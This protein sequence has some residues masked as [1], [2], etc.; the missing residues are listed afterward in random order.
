[1]CSSTPT[2]HGGYELSM[3]DDLGLDV[4]PDCCGDD[5]T[6][7]EKERGYV[8]YTCGDCAT[9]LTVSPNGLVFDISE[10]ANA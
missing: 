1:M 2:V 3:G 7:E 8:D 6:R 10:G 4:T 5:M 9:I